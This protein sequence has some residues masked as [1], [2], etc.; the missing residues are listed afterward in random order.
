MKGFYCARRE[1]ARNYSL[2]IWIDTPATE[3]LRRGI[4]RDGESAR[5]RWEAEWM[6][7]E[8]LYVAAH[9]PDLA[10]EMVLD[11]SGQIP[12]NI[13]TQFIYVSGGLILLG[14]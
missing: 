14:D 11:G 9:R 8:E 3:R 13:E 4:E 2:R 10:A 5:H 12:H 1:L 7:A 6:P